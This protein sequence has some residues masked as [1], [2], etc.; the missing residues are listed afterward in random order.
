M[1]QCY[2]N[3]DTRGSTR[4]QQSTQTV[5]REQDVTELRDTI[6]ERWTPITEYRWDFGEA[7]VWVADTRWHS[8][9]N[10]SSRVEVSRV[11]F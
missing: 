11:V 6:R 2:S 8:R 3:L 4:T 5:Y 1:A 9:L 7:Y 10:L